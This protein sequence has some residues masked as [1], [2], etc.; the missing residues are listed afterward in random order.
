MPC[1]GPG[2]AKISSAIKFNSIGGGYIA[3][4]AFICIDFT[5]TLFFFWKWYL[6][7]CILSDIALLYSQT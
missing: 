5:E 7:H 1:W 6:K 3:C 4:I 2:M